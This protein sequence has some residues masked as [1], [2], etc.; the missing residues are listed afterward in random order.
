MFFALP[1]TAQFVTISG[2]VYDISAKRPLE[3]VAVLSTSGR[4]TITDSAGR[5]SL[6]I[7]ETDSI[8]FSLLGKTTMKYPV[9]TI[10][11]TM[12]FNVMIHVRAQDLP[13]VKVRN[14]YYRF[15]SI[16][17][18]RD[19]AKVFEFKKPGISLS[20]PS[21][22]YN[23][24]HGVTV[25]IDLVEF[26]NMFRFK[27]NRQMLA[28]QKRLLQQ[29]RDKHIDH[30]FKKILV[31]KLTGLKS[32]ELEQFMEAYRPKYE[33]LQFMNELELGYYIQQCYE[34]YKMGLPNPY[35]KIFRDI[36]PPDE[37]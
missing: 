21:P 26:I 35:E 16:Q 9:D 24:T 10:T 3:A 34:A 29:E 15:D 17:N 32:P 18:R 1:V 25:G 5:Y 23:T 14:N 13:E 33:W 36:P 8:W 20:T 12:G 27:R 28:L 31:I 22:T 11:N 6:T 4:G 19:Y 37:E 7:K 2:T 30:R